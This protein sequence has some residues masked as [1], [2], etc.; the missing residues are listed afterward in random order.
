MTDWNFRTFS[1]RFNIKNTEK[2][3]PIVVPFMALKSHHR[4]SE[5][6]DGWFGYPGPQL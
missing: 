2:P 4:K 6:F 3:G 1:G 5:I